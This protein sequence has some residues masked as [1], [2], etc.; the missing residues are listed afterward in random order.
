MSKFEELS[1]RN[2]HI[3][4]IETDMLP[5]FQDGCYINGEIYINKNLNDEQKAEVLHEELAHHKLTYGNITDQSIFNNRKFEG[6]ARRQ[7]Y[8]WSLP[9]QKI[10][11]AYISGVNSLY[12]LAEFTQLSESY[13]DV[14]LD[15]YKQKHGLSTWCGNYLIQFEPLHVYKY[16]NIK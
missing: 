9:L 16:K 2:D 14:V 15:Y 6:Y 12:E 3:N 1:I 7:A 5:K 13:V 11:D 10:I 8:E 4:I